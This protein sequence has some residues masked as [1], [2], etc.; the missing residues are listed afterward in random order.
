MTAVLLLM[1]AQMLLATAERCR[2]ALT[3]IPVMLLARIESGCYGV[4]RERAT[5]APSMSLFD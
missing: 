5:T 1:L 2:L 3:D 4:Q